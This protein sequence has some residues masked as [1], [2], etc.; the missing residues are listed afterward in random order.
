MGGLRV[1]RLGGLAKLTLATLLSGSLMS[2]AGATWAESCPRSETK[3]LLPNEIPGV[4]IPAGQIDAAVA[5]VDG[6]A[7]ALIVSSG[8]P[9]MA[10]AVVVNGKV[11]FA[12]GYGVRRVT[13]ADQVDADTVFQLASM[14]K[15]IGATVV[16]HQVSKGIIGWDTPLQRSMPAFALKDPYVSSHVTIGDM[17]AHRSGL[18]DHAGDLLEDIGYDRA[19]IL[20]RLRYLPLTQFRTQYAYTNFGM[21]AGAQAVAM[22][23]GVEWADLSETVLYQPLG[24]TSTSSRYADF[25]ARH[26]RAT[27]HVKAA[28]G[29]RVTPSQRLPDAQ[30]PAGGVSSSV[31]DVARWMAMVLAEGC[32]GTAAL[33]NRDA[34]QAAISP[35]IVSAPPATPQARAGFYGYGVNVSDSAAGRVVLSHSGAFT[36]GAATA[37]TLLPSTGVG[38]VTLT[39]AQPVGV[40]ETLNAMFA[41]LVQFGRVTQ[42]WQGLY[43]GAFAHMISPEGTLVGKARPSAPVS[44]RALSEYA[45]SYDN[46]FYG[47]ATVAVEGHA[48]VLLLGPAKIRLPLSHWSGDV[49]VFTPPGESQSEGSISK[50]TFHN[51]SLTV[52][53][54][55]DEQLGTFCLRG[56]R[57]R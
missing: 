44:A 41:D 56:T 48:L 30:S 17:Y 2:Y 11:V 22:A 40:P 16:A 55:D 54:L 4:T 27:P 14:S 1:C 50:A 26:N 45:G 52:E 19:Q 57:C 15:S 42:D 35:Q 46:V 21:T 39:N 31:N 29:Y 32:A 7:Q 37:F 8:I 6:L 18:P 3:V 36:L 47:E 51:G 25:A 38:I 5:R 23:S 10:V 12:K 53:Y 49:F 33:V 9:G 34:L 13:S 43:A 20:E 24:M 28:E